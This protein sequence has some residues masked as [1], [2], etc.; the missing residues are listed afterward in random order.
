MHTQLLEI[1]GICLRISADSSRLIDLLRCTYADFTVATG[2]AAATA[3]L[4]AFEGDRPALTPASPVVR[5][6]DGSHVVFWQR[7]RGRLYPQERRLEASIEC[8][9][10]SLNSALRLMLANCLPSFGGVLLHAAGFARAGRAYAFAGASGAGKSTLA[11]MTL[12]NRPECELL[13]DEILLVR[14][15]SGAWQAY[16]TPFCG[17]VRQSGRNRATPLHAICFLEKADAHEALPMSRSAAGRSILKNAFVLADT[18]PPE[19]F[20]DLV[21]D[22][23]AQVP[24]HKLRLRP[25]AGFWDLL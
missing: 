15:A 7:M 8:D 18:G 3:E 24:A 10:A 19:V 22:L 13:T 2:T 11:R 1:G 4:R 5:C 6:S 12:M 16:G 21:L 23:A 14:R 25:D 20:L 17:D 9:W